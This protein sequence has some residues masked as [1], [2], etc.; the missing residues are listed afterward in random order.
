MRRVHHAPL[1]ACTATTLHNACQRLAAEDGIA[2]FDVEHLVA[3]FPHLS[4]EV[5]SRHARQ[6]YVV[7]RVELSGAQLAVQVIDTA[8]MHLN[9]YLALLELIRQVDDLIA[10]NRRAAEARNRDG[11]HFP[12]LHTILLH[13]RQATPWTECSARAHSDVFAV[14]ACSTDPGEQ[15][16]DTTAPL[17]RPPSR[18]SSTRVGAAQCIPATMRSPCL[19]PPAAATSPFRG[20]AVAPLPPP[21]SVGA[22]DFRPQQLVNFDVPLALAGSL[23][24]SAVSCRQLPGAQAAPPHLRAALSRIEMMRRDLS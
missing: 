20:L 13:Y 14:R 7:F 24:L 9:K 19:H 8:R 21:P 1:G 12:I 6:A 23:G 11:V 16:G 5:S 4:A 18:W 10:Q 15:T 2:N 3:D 22:V 17:A